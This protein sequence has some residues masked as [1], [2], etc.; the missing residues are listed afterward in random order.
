MVLRKIPALGC[1]GSESGPAGPPASREALEVR[2]G[3]LIGAGARA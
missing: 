3:G 1:A 2:A